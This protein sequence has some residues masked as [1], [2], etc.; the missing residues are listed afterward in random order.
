MFQDNQPFLSGEEAKKR[1]SRW[2]PFL[3]FHL[4]N[5]SYFDLQVTPMLPT[6]WPSVQE[7]KLKIDF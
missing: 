1:F 5:F 3:I 6:K 2:W 7:K 4:N